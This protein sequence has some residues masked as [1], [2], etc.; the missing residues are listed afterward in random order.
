MI[1]KNKI[2]YCDGDMVFFFVKKLEA[3]DFDLVYKTG[4]FS[5]FYSAVA[6]LLQLDG[7]PSFFYFKSIYQDLKKIDGLFAFIWKAV[8]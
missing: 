2:L 3:F 6:V 1:P 8:T 7:S 4:K 5:N